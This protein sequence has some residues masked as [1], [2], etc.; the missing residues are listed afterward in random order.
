MQLELTSYTE[1]SDNKLLTSHTETEC[2]EIFSVLC[3]FL[4][5]PPSSNV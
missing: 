3:I 2:Q 5:L 1:S 4:Q